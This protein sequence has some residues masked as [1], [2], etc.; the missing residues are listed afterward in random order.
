MDGNCGGY[1]GGVL[2]MGLLHGRERKDFSDQ[3]KIGRANELA[4]KLRA[5]FLEEYGGVTCHDVKRKVFGRTFNSQDPEDKKAWEEAGGPIDEC[6]SV[7]GKAAP[8]TCEIILAEKDNT[9]PGRATE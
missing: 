2:A 9:E 3:D 5:R 6:P 8:W 7:V 1:L 4:R